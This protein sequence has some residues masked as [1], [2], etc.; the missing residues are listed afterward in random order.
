MS[1]A[2]EV[3]DDEVDSFLSA[4]INTLQ[5]RAKHTD[6]DDSSL[7]ILYGGA[8]MT[9]ALVVL[10]IFLL[11]MTLKDIKYAETRESCTAPF[12][13]NPGNENIGNGIDGLASNGS[14]TDSTEATFTTYYTCPHEGNSIPH[15]LVAYP[16]Q[17]Q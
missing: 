16:C 8:G 2:G 9:I 1:E 6:E 7:Y 17:K 12:F 3:K 4:D 10:S 11:G 13:T 5:N 14:T 15:P